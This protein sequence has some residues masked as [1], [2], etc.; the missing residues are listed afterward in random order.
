V[1]VP[2]GHAHVTRGSEDEPAVL[3]NLGLRPY[4]P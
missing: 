3:R 2:S 1:F 4:R